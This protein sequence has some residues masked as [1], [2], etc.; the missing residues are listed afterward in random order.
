L[1]QISPAICADIQR[2]DA[3]RLSGQF[4]QA[5]SEY[6]HV[7]ASQIDSLRWSE[8]GFRLA[9]CFAARGDYQ[10]ALR[11]YEEVTRRFPG[12]KRTL[13]AAWHMLRLKCGPLQDRKGALE[14]ARKLANSRPASLYT[15]RG[16]YSQALIHFWDKRPEQS[17]EVLQA[18][19][20]TYGNGTYAA[21][22]VQLLA[23][24]EKGFPREL[25]KKGK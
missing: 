5:E 19:L 23:K 10:Q 21:A 11:G 20:R 4:Q 2:A 12:D 13:E 22:A 3:L 7:L 9:E 6:R 17:K 15:E 25:H 14:I 8:A 1:A 18:Y 24:L 16:L